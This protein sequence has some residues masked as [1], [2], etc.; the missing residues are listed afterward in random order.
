MRNYNLGY[1]T[2]DASNIRDIYTNHKE[3]IDILIKEN[4]LGSLIGICRGY[5]PNH[6]LIIGEDSI[7]T[8]DTNNGEPL[9]VSLMIN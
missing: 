1:G 2:F 7:L 9:K 5:L 3:K 8:V 4:N 6:L